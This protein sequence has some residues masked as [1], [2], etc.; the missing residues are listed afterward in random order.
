MEWLLFFEIIPRKHE[1]HTLNSTY[2]VSECL[3]LRCIREIPSSV[4]GCKVCRYPKNFFVGY[5]IT[6]LTQTVG[7]IL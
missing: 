3:Q 2:D 6:C 1:D 4:L 7:L 5:F